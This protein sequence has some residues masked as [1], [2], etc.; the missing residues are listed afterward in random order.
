VA[1]LVYHP[2]RFDERC[3]ALDEGTTVIGRAAECEICI[4]DNG[5][6]RRHSAIE[7]IGGKSYLIDL[8]S[9]NGSFV[10]GVR[11]ERERIQPDDVIRLGEVLFTL[12][13][14][15][16]RANERAPVD[17]LPTLVMPLTNIPIGELRARS[18][19][20]AERARARL[21]ILLEVS[22]ALAGSEDEASLLEQ[23]L[24]LVFESFDADRV[25]IL[26][27]DA[28]TGK[29]APWAARCGEGHEGPSYSR[30]I[31]AYVLKRGVAAL[32][33]EPAIDP[34]LDASDSIVH[35]AIS[36]A[37][38]APLRARGKTLGVLY[39]DNLAG[40]GRLDVGDLELFAAVADHAALALENAARCRRIEEEAVARTQLAM[41]AK[42]ASLGAM[43]AGIA[44]EL[45]NPLNFITNFAELSG[46][47]AAEVAAG[48]A[49]ERPRITPRAYADLAASLAELEQDARKILDHGRRADAIIGTMLLHASGASRQRAAAD[50]NAVLAQS[51][52]VAV[53]GM[54]ARDAAFD[55]A[56]DAA[57][58]ES[59]GLVEMVSADLHRA[60]VNVLDNAC[61]AMREKRRSLGAGY[62]PKLTVRTE[63]A[64]EWVEILIRDNGPGIPREIE[65]RVFHPFFTT[66]PAGEGTGLGLSLS[67][68]IVVD[69]HRG[70]IRLSTSPGEQTTVIIALPRRAPGSRPA[71]KP[72]P[73]ND[74]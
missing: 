22:R 40:Q 45:R 73:A 36:A 61:Y 13:D 23:I 62:A 12:A 74:L 65:G 66:R 34:R 25:A 72:V 6:S 68:D 41:E 7:T 33:A 53:E 16:P 63:V 10:N 58:D 70:S 14:D 8:K 30:K 2:G 32:F 3:F 38:A 56:V 71:A 51:V 46:E 60:L 31:A 42:L 37:M 27:L 11:V 48:L 49:T 59:I 69:G 54:R 64:G 28:T 35:Q 20:A 17:P 19:D 44:H 52:L 55:V 67:R 50:P 9:K 57:Y 47:L 43:V 29:L 18:G 15:G 1:Q 24:D 4:L 26:L 5:L 21:A 39:L